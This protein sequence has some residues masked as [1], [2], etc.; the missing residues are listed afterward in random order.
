VSHTSGGLS[1]RAQPGAPTQ[2]PRPNHRRLHCTH[3]TYFTYF[4]Y[5]TSLTWAPTARRWI[6]FSVSEWLKCTAERNASAEWKCT[7]SMSSAR[8]LKLGSVEL[9]STK[10]KPWYLLVYTGAG[11]DHG[12][13]TM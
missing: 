6:W 8:R 12:I 4:T 3:C 1:H 5:F 2:R 11:G 7:S 13:A 10:R 9:T